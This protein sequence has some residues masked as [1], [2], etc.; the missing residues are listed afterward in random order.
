MDLNA[1]LGRRDLFISTVLLTATLPLRRASAAADSAVE[2]TLAETPKDASPKLTVER[3]GQVALLGINRPYIQNRVDP[4]TFHALGR[5]YYDYDRDP[6]L[7]AAIL[8]GHGDHFSRGID[9]DAFT[10]LARTGEPLLTD[11]DVIDPLAKRKPL[12]DKATDRRGPRGY[13]EHGRR[14]FSSRR[15]PGR[16]RQYELWPG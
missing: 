12:V 13:V 14:A 4:E 3:R 8:F 16:G 15:Y 2:A 5:A 11:N 10:A 7:R 9:V 1:G 6:S